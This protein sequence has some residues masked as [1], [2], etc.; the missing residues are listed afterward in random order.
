MTDTRIFRGW[1]MAAADVASMGYLA[2]MRGERVVV[3]GAANKA[4]V[5]SIR[6]SPRALVAKVGRV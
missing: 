1:L 6:F 2:L 4:L 5:W 3:T